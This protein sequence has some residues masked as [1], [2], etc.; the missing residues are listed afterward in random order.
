MRVERIIW[1]AIFTS[2]LIYL[3]VAFLVAQRGAAR[4]FEEAVRGSN[5]LVLY[6]VSLV[7]FLIGTFPP[8][9]MRNQPPRVRMI[10]KLAIFES[11]AVYG[12]V[13]AF[14]HSDWR[15]YLAPWALAIVGFL[16]TYPTTEPASS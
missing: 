6:A 3:L 15:L 13:A 7:A 9:Q 12:L 16:R 14:M 5:V 10:T 4:S 1:F 8:A 11:C 2:T